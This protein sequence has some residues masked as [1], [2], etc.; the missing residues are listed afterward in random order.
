MASTAVK[1]HALDALP[2]LANCLPMAALPDDESDPTAAPRP[3]LASGVG[4]RWIPTVTLESPGRPT[5]DGWPRFE[6]SRYTEIAK[7]GDGGSSVVVKAL[8]NELQR[9]VAI[10]ILIADP[11]ENQLRAERFKTEARITGHIEHPN[12]VP[13]YELGMDGHGRSFLAMKLVE[14]VDLEDRLQQLG[15]RRLESAEL[16]KLLQV[17]TKV[18]DAVSFAHSRGVIH[19]DLKPRNIRDGEF[20]QV[21]VLDWGIARLLPSSPVRASSVPQPPSDSDPYGLRV[22]TDGYMPPEQILGR[23]DEVDERADVFALG[24]TLYQFLAGRP[25]M[26]HEIVTAILEGK[27]VPAIPYPEEVAVGLE[28]PA[29]LARIAL[30]ALAYDPA[31]RYPSVAHLKS[32][33]EA[34]QR[35]TW[36]LPRKKVPA[37]TVIIVEGDVGDAAYVIL[38]GQCEAYRLDGATEILLRVM[39]PGDVFGETAIL[40]RKPRTANVRAKTDAV[41]L[42]VT[43]DVLS[44]ALGLNSWMGAF[45]KALA[46]RFREADLQ[47][48]AR[49]SDLPVESGGIPGLRRRPS[50]PQAPTTLERMMAK[51]GTGGGFQPPPELPRVT[52]EAGATVVRA[53]E[54]GHAGYFVLK[55][56]CLEHRDDGS[57]VIVLRDLGPNNVFGEWALFSDTPA[58]TSV[59]AKSDVELVVVERS[60]LFEALGLNSWMGAFVQSLAERL[61]EANDRLHERERADDS[62]PPSEGG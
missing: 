18:C 38:D 56:R 29:E 15:E 31:E 7:V 30:H 45:V 55:G 11:L 2:W 1:L 25:P 60:V 46:E 39:G 41:L 42:R 54:A 57:G 34:F 49:D 47:L 26:T 59:V 43:E 44:R 53:G 9:S 51:M 33:V 36:D 17:F 58:P 37:G 5:A 10:K 24:A 14:G 50:A 62:P 19:R 21:H 6:T 16:T 12:I 28:P 40:S 32:D 3:T 13:V 52:F 22:G 23:H 48:R 27:P 20:G 4:G 61:R 35:G 8:D